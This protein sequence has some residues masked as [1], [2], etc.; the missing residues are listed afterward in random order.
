VSVNWAMGL[1]QSNPGETFANA[2]QQGMQR[3]EQNTAKQALATLV[4]DPTNQQALQVLARADPA[5]AQQFQQQHLEQ[6]KQQLAQHQ[7]SIIKGAQIIRQIN[8]TDQPSW[9][10]A[11]AVAQQAGI[12]VSGAPRQFDP[13]YARGMVS[14]ADAFQPQ[15]EGQIVPYTQGGGVAQM[16]P[17]THQLQTLVMPNEGGH[18]TGAPVGNVP[19]VHDQASYDAVPPGSSYITPDGHTRVKQGGQMGA[20]PSGGFQ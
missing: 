8:P 9:E 10:R 3:N 14:L 19:Q 20:A 15:K 18:Q 16:N 5:A 2:F 1:Q 11:L 13:N 6:V 4:Q 7:D 12:D 17:H